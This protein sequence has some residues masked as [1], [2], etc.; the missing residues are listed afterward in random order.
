V[1]GCRAA[2]YDFR[3]L[4][5]HAK[6]AVCNKQN[7]EP[8]RDGTRN[9]ERGFTDARLDGYVSGDEIDGS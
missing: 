2:K 3:P 8:K 6:A 1:G 9:R 5:Q 4:S 7:F